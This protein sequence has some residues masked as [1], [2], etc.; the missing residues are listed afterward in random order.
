MKN[1]GFKKS[2]INGTE[3]TINLPQTLDLPPFYSYE[4]VLPEVIDQGSD[5]ICVPCSI[6]SYLNWRENLN[7]GEPRDNGINLFEI[8]GWK[9]TQG[10]GMTFKEAFYNL[11][12]RGVSSD[13]GRMKI[14]EYA[15][16]RNAIEL[17]YAI[18]A[19][20]PC[21]GALPVYNNSKYFWRKNGNQRVIGFHAI[22]IVGYTESGF[23]IRNSW[24][25]GF[26]ENGYTHLTNEETGQLL[27]AWSIVG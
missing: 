3:H 18:L 26:G 19:N 1:Y 2:E 20:G 9:T 17:K 15:L 4:E 10:D 13:K 21:F 8:Y 5:P 27:E 14:G 12:R 6:S 16:I 11:R 22:A 23:I 25:R 7:D 24:G